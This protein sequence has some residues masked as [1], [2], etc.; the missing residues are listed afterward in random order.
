[1]EELRCGMWGWARWVSDGPTGH[2]SFCKIPP[3]AGGSREL[4][5]PGPGTCVLCH[6]GISEPWTGLTRW[7]RPGC[8]GGAKG[9]AAARVAS[10]ICSLPACS[11]QGA[12]GES[13]VWKVVMLSQDLPLAGCSHRRQRPWQI[14]KKN[15]NT[16]CGGKKQRGGVCGGSMGAAWGGTRCRQDGVHGVPGG[17]LWVPGCPMFVC[18][19]PAE[20]AQSP[21]PVHRTPYTPTIGDI[22]HKLPG[23]ACY[24]SD[25]QAARGHG[26]PLPQL[27]IPC[28]TRASPH[29]CTGW[30]RS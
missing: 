15:Q 8:S 28:Q 2:H 14:K 29:K 9:L 21:L 7:H 5:V 4:M 22:S 26:G 30:E 10:P 25:T 23:C 11:G 20:G 27:C 19:M 13:L 16:R 1:M 6:G 18:A 17:G 12:G 24:R 3:A